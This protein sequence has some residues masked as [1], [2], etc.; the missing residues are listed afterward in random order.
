MKL[1]ISFLLLAVT[2]Y[3]TK[4]LYYWSKNSIQYERKIERSE[5]WVL[6]TPMHEGSKEEYGEDRQGEGENDVRRIE[7]FLEE[8]GSPLAGRGGEIVAIG[9]AFGI[10]PFLLVSISV[11]ESG[12]GKHGFCGNV[13]GFGRYCFSDPIL[14][15]RAVAQALAGEGE[16]GRYYEKCKG[17][18]YCLLE[19]YNSENK[20]YAEAVINQKDYIR[21]T[22]I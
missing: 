17:G 14:G 11:I 8:Y 13:L 6:P 16:N 9:N 1:L 22:P 10:D 4:R 12:A 20:E 2:I 3:G 18:E 7:A 15:F 5:G 19:V 21:N